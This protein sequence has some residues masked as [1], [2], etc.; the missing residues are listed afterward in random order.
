MY[1]LR[2]SEHQVTAWK[3][4]LIRCMVGLI[5]VPQLYPVRSWQETQ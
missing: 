5:D 3:S 4:T 2:V 1:C